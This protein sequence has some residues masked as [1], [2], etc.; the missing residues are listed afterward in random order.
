MLI[1]AF[2]ILAVAVLLGSVLAFLHLQTE[3]TTRPW[4]LAALQGLFAIGGLSCPAL[5][6][7]ALLATLIFKIRIPEIMIVIHAT[8]A[9]GGFVILAAYVLVG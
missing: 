9:V 3:S 1:A 4:S 7:V 2:V 6:G 8:F 5:I